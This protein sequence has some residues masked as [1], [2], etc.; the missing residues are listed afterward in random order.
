MAKISWPRRAISLSFWIFSAWYLYISGI[1]T[2]SLNFVD[3]LI[4]ILLANLIFVSIFTFYAGTGKNKDILFQEAFGAGSARFIISPL[5]AL[6][7]IGWFAVLVEAGGGALANALNV[8]TDS[9]VGISLIA[10]YGLIA[11]W[12]ACRG[13]G[14][15]DRLSLFAIFAMVGFFGWGAYKAFSQLGASGIF[16]YQPSGSAGIF[17][18]TQL[19]LA[20]FISAAVTIPDFLHDLGNKKKIFLASFWG[21]LP[22]AVAVGALGSTLAIIGKDY[23]VLKTLQFLSGP[24]FIY[25]LFSIDNLKPIAIFPV[26]TS[27][28]SLHKQ[29]EDVAVNEK[30]RKLWTIAGGVIAIIFAEIGIVQH[31]PEWLN[32]LS[33]VFAPII[34]VV[35]ANQ[36]IVKEN[37]TDKRCHF[38]A[39]LAWGAGCAA[40]FVPFGIPMPQSLLVAFAIFILLKKVFLPS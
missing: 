32:I 31:L 3:T 33:I 1:A 21:L 40:S 13:L 22:T 26:G 14:T 2:Q 7:Q 29:S 16:G 39:L 35:L 37:S 6:A 15:I 17:F 23:D 18:G 20:A 36:Y 4:S 11:T 12:I 28:A 38:L 24:F 10:L 34:G 27:F 9:I 25:L 19:F 30:R 8:A 5:P